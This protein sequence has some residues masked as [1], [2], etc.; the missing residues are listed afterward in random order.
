MSS[1]EEWSKQKD[2]TK[3]LKKWKTDL[4]IK[5]IVPGI[6]EESVHFN[7]LFLVKTKKIVIEYTD[8]TKIELI[9]V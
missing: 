8:R 3:V 7:T 1:I 4:R 5:E 9:Y 2:G 6:K